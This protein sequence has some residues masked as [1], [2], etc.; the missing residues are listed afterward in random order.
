MGKSIFII[1]LCRCFDLQAFCFCLFFSATEAYI[2]KA[3]FIGIWEVHLYKYHWRHLD[4]I[5]AK[6][7]R[8]I[9]LRGV[10]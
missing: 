1:Q 4:D 2:T 3:E 9:N 8:L 10:F 5:A 6:K 7:Q